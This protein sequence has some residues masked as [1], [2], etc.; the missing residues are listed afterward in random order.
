MFNKKL[1][2]QRQIQPA[3][4]I[5]VE[6]P[7][8]DDLILDGSS[9]IRCDLLGSSLCDDGPLKDKTGD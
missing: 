6:Y 9:D 7:F 8:S 1:T 5:C 2:N 3:T 4:F